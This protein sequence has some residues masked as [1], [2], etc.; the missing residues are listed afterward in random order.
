MRKIKHLIAILIMILFTSCST[1]SEVHYFKDRVTSS[2]TGDVNVVPNYY[3]VNIS[4]YSLLS[5]SRY[6]SGY[7]D[8]NAID[9]YFN[10]TVQPENA[11][12]QNTKIDSDNNKALITNEIGNELVLVLSTNAKAVTE[13][14]GNI[15][16][17]QTILNS[18]AQLTQKDKINEANTIKSEISNI[19]N[20]TQNFILKTDLYLNELSSRTT[21]GEKKAG[22]KNYF[23]TIIN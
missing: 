22:I 3:K 17:N 16:K 2:T 15:A 20:D 13:Q 23:S 7:F 10:E 4:G 11:K 19:T 5:S 9:L 8:Q 21:D 18:L 1:F 12:L 6:V 14:I